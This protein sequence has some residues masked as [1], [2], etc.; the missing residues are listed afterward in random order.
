[1]KDNREKNK[2]MDLVVSFVIKFEL[3]NRIPGWSVRL[4]PLVNRLY[5]SKENK[6]KS[7]YFTILMLLGV[8]LLGS[9]SLI[10]IFNKF[11]ISMCFTS[12]ILT[13]LVPLLIIRRLNDQL[14]QRTRAIT[15]E[16][17]AYT[18]SVMLYVGA[19]YPIPKAIIHAGEHR[20][21]QNQEL[22]K[23]PFYKE[24]NK[25]IAALRNN[26]QFID[27]MV[28]L[29]HRCG[30]KEISM[31]I[32]AIISQY[33]RGSED[34]IYALHDLSRILWEQRKV[35]ARILGEETAS[36]ILLPMMI[37]FLNVMTIVSAP[38]IFLM[39]N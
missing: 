30:S 29:S 24:L 12:V 4:Q 25:T 32:S 26:T 28:S 11:S 38:A 36:R 2:I 17:P 23:H 33:L 27:A 34:F 7:A 1:M 13:C 14:K 5:D 22:V 21:A 37:I 18:N 39:Q 19:G 8:V 6:F 35:T 16:L 20:L 31:F 9:L 15:L 10:L 3:H